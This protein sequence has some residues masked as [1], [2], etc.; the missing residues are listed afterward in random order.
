MPEKKKKAATKNNKQESIEATLWQAADKL[1]KNMDAAEYKHIVFAERFAKLKAELEGQMAEEIRLNA[2]I[3][4]N[5]A[6]LE[7]KA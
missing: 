2:L 5:L 1:R 3:Q 4:E 7:I 6:R